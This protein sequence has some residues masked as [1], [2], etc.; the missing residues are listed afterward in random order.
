VSRSDGDEGE[1]RE[2]CESRADVIDVT[3]A[4]EDPR[5]VLLVC[6]IGRGSGWKGVREPRDEI[7]GGSVAAA[8]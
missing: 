2:R 5:P 3:R 1:R 4:A 7:N 6:D 8:S